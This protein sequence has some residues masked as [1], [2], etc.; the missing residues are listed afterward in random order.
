[1]KIAIVAAALLSLSAHAATEVSFNAAATS[2]YRY[3]GISQTR[4]QPAL[5]GG[6]DLVHKPSG[7]YA[8]A[9][10]STIKWTN[11]AGGDGKV[12]IDIYG[13]K[14]GELARGIGYDAGVLTYAYPSNRLGHVAGFANANTTEVYG[15]LS[16]GV[17][18]IKYSHALTNL[19]GYVD[20]KHSGY[21]DLAAN[22]ELGNGFVLNLHAGRQRVANNGAA[23]YTD[24]KIGVTRDFGV[25]SV[26]LAA[27]GTNAG[28]A[29][30]A[31]PANGKFLGKT[32][33]QLTV[34]KTF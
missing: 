7:W 28:K 25:A 2:D 26:A 20:S 8:G 17:A 23:S 3:R 30:Y 32:A 12:E 33:L 34:S 31:S 4:L 19:F 1:M 14:R 24:Y 6:A 13:G 16:Y 5:Q 15:Q 11:D 29:A 9:W 10:A 22:P 21:L 18:L 27:I